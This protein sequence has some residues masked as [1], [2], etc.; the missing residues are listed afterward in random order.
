MLIQIFVE[1]AVKH[2]LMVYDS[3]DKLLKLTICHIDSHIEITVANTA[4]AGHQPSAPGTGTGMRVATQ[5]IAALN[6]WN[7]RQ[8]DLRQSVADL[9]DGRKLFSIILT[10][11]DDFNYSA[12]GRFR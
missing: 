2:G 11:P 12:P 4:P 6:A 5:T 9:P 1:N 7:R 8:I 3:P 10:I